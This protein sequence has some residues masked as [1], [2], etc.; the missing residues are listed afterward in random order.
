MK[1]EVE[2]PLSHK[3][4]AWIRIKKTFDKDFSLRLFVGTEE[5]HLNWIIGMDL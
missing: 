4:S 3:V 2:N 1:D 5:K